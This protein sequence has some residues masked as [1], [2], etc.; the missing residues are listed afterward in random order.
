VNLF[1]TTVGIAT[2][3]WTAEGL[4]FESR[5]GER[6]FS[7]PR[8]PLRF[9]GISNLM[10]NEYRGLFP[11]VKRTEHEAHNLPMTTAE[12]RNTWIYTCHPPY[13]FMA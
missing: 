9:W 2:M 12:F 10:S 6:F 11:G 13:I 5:K 4:E 8:Y 3:D 1:V 7:S